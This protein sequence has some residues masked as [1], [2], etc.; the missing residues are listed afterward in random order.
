MYRP[1]PYNS[2]TQEQ[3]WMSIFGDAHDS[4]CGCD[5]PYAHALTRMFPEG[6]KD[7][8][9]TVQQI[10][11][12]DTKCHFG[13]TEEGNHGLA[14]TEDAG[15]GPSKQP[16][17]DGIEDLGDTQIEELIAAADAAIAR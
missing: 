6:H 12:R 3:L 10:I 5:T 4:F 8:Q 11:D 9:L 16:E 2:D 14:N 15:E 1:C 13:G 17:E 7:R